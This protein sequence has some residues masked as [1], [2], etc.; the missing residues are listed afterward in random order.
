MLYSCIALATDRS[1]EGQKQH[2]IMT[3]E[4]AINLMPPG[5]D[6]WFWLADFE[7]FSVTDV[8]MVSSSCPTLPI[9]SNLDVQ[10]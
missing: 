3:F 9:C 8:G 7:G 4:Q 6:K 5:V 1:T 2:M 10:R